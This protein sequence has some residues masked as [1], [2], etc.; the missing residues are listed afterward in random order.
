MEAWNVKGWGEKERERERNSGILAR[1]PESHWGPRRAGLWFPDAQMTSCLPGL[2]TPGP[3]RVAL[4][5]H[6]A[7]FVLELLR[8]LRLS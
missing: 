2:Q 8:K 6:C 4:P 3:F 5:C 1:E 7:S